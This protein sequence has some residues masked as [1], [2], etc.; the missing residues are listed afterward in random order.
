LIEDGAA[1][2]EAFRQEFFIPSLERRV[3]RIAEFTAGAI[4]AEELPRD[5]LT[6]Q[7]LAEANQLWSTEAA[8]QDTL[9]VLAGGLQ[10]TALGV[11][12]TIDHRA[13]ISPAPGAEPADEPSYRKLIISYPVL[14]SSLKA[15]P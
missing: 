2:V 15:P 8:V 6:Q 12:Q 10:T 3:E 14:F 4:S 9:A 11:T 5:V 13:G 7:L 1:A